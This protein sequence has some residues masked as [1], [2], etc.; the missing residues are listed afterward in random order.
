[1]RRSLVAAALAVL[2]TFIWGVGE[3]AARTATVTSFDGTKI[4]VNFFPTDN[5]MHGKR[6]PTVLFGPGWSSPGDTNPEGQTDVTVGAVGVGPLRAAGYNVLT[7]DPRGFGA[8]GGTVEVDSPDYEARDVKKLISWVAKQPEAQL[9]SKRDP[10]VGMTGASY[11]GGIQLSVAAL[12]KRVDAIV[13]DIAW[14]SLTTS[15]YKD[16]TFKAGWG[17]LL[18]T[19]GKAAG[20]L[21][22]HID[23]AFD[24]GTATGHISAADENWFRSRGPG[25]LVRKIHVPTLLVQ[26]TV[27]T[28]F[29]LNEAVTNYRI[30][31]HHGVPV[32]ML[33]FCGG[34]GGCLTDQGDTDLIEKRSIAWLDHWLAG[35]RKVKTGPG[36]QWLNQ[37]GQEFSAKRWPRKHRTIEAHGSGSLPITEAG[38]S[39]PS[40][41]G[42]GAVGAVS[43]ITNGTKALNAVN[44]KIPGKGSDKQIVGAPK[45]ALRYSATGGPTDTRVYAQLVD[46]DTDVVLGNQVTPIPI[47][48]DGRT[49]TIK[50]PLEMVA[51]TLR[52][53][54]SVTL[55]VTASATNYGLQRSAGVADLKKVALK[56]P[57]VKA[58]KKRR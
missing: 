42:P 1:M 21:D 15:L 48:L 53:G 41:P 26:G 28:L 22:P 40:K 46:D 56:L 39:G 14:H 18:Y 50:R 13:P 6:S 55:Q 32:K 45:L 10:R 17:T 38:G 37:D 43:G 51:H 4:H 36:F 5:P 12:D 3:A 33:W 57:V 47:K 52:P 35:E 49:H 7:W 30:L 29:T 44:V 23:S 25:N 19:L 27:D 31:H 34:H 54:S 58:A 8:S 16:S 9:D 2:A 24:S 20:T 11:G